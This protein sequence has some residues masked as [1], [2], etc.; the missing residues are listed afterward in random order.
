MSGFPRQMSRFY[1]ARNTPPRIAL[2]SLTIVRAWSWM[3]DGTLSMS[4]QVGPPRDLLANLGL[5]LLPQ[6]QGRACRSRK[7]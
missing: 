1:P 6:H 7:A 2:N 5:S 3:C 4:E